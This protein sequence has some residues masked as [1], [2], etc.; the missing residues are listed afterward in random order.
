MKNRKHFKTFVYFSFYETFKFYFIVK[1]GKRQRP[2]VRDVT[3]YAGATETGKQEHARRLPVNSRVNRGAASDQHP[4]SDI[5]DTLTP[6]YS[7]VSHLELLFLS[8]V[9]TG[10]LA[11]IASKRWVGDN[12]V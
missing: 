8:N 5:A 1:A 12:V 7:D 6:L 10:T 2:V 11:A 3:S 9:V 4:V